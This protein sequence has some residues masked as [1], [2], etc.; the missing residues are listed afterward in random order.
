MRADRLLK[1]AGFLEKL[2]KEKFDFSVIV[3]GREKPRK[4]LDCGS[5]A[6]AIGWCPVVFPRL[7]EY[8]NTDTPWSLNSMVVVPKGAKRYVASHLAK[9][10]EHLFDIPGR[11]AE[12]LFSPARQENIGL[13]A[14]RYNATPKQVAALIRRFVA[15][16]SK[17]KVARA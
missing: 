14:L 6:C 4:Q 16:N 2:P 15:K 11:D 8:K 5:V 7:C 9:V 12:D 17:K 1:L 3:R 10:A 13:K